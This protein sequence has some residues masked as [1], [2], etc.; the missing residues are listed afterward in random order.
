MLQVSAWSWAGGYG[1]VRLEGMVLCNHDLDN[2]RA[3]EVLHNP[4]NGPVRASEHVCLF[5][6]MIFKNACD[7]GPHPP[8]RNRKDDSQHTNKQIQQTNG[9]QPHA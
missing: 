3:P 4:Q 7:S 5:N 9:L 1:S 6:Y 2:V 8:C